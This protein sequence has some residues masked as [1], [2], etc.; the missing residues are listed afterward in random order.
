LR[1]ADARAAKTFRPLRQLRK[2]VHTRVDVYCT[3]TGWG[4]VEIDATTI[5]S[6]SRSARRPS[7]RSPSAEWLCRYRQDR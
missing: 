5:G 1:G 4:S 6:A 7:M 2:H 3:G